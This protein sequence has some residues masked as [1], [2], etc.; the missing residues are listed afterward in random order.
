MVESRQDLRRSGVHAPAL[1]VLAITVALLTVLAPSSA[2]AATT[3]TTSP[4]WRLG[5]TST[6][7]GTTAVTTA[8]RRV[9]GGARRTSCAPRVADPS[10]A[11]TVTLSYRST[12]PVRVGLITRDARGWHLARLS[13]PQ[14]AS[15]RWRP[16]TWR[17]PALAPGTTVASV[18]LVTAVRA[19]AYVARL[20]LRTATPAAS[21][22]VSTAPV[23][24]LPRRVAAT[25]WTNWAPGTPLD[26]LP[27][28]YNVIFAAFAYGDGSGTGR[29][30]FRPDDGSG[31]APPE[32]LRQMRAAQATGDQVVLSIG[33]ANPVGLR[34]LT[35]EHVDQL[36]A[37]IEGI[38]DAYG[39]DGV[40]WDLEQA[41][42]YTV[43][44]LLACT[45]A[46]KTRYGAQ[47][48]VTAT[49]AP[50]SRPYKVFAQQAGPLLDY[51][52]PQYYDYADPDRLAGILSRTREL[53][54]AYGVPA[55]KIG[56]GTRV[57][58][59]P[60]SAP[61]TFWRDAL[62][63]VRT[64]YPDLAGASVWEAAGERAAGDP[65]ARL[66]APTALAP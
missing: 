11:R 22:P 62:A 19:R 13:G 52:A 23:S 61:A 59:D 64:T 15:G 56:I 48:L 43:E 47:F 29:A 12:R 60:L 57:G 51:V 14:R 33:G 24:A 26:Q 32:F 17:V 46:W 65:F 27:A 2:S 5:S 28:A 1:L 36:V 55:R 3:S 30:V 35:A 63:A 44:N 8:M 21:A 9:L 18:G 58:A 40:D 10:A 16:V 41:D 25:Y 6:R 50:S 49:P 54:T 53:V 45:R 39:F 66:V 20:T 31:T 7:Y 34:L 4:C 42:G 37:S 38:V